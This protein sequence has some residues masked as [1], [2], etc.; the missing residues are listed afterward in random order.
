MANELHHHREEQK[1]QQPKK[2]KKEVIFCHAER[3]NMTDMSC[4]IR[5]TGFSLFSKF[6]LN[7][8]NAK[9]HSENDCQTKSEVE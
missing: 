2:V 7:L 6:E 4:E 1:Q 5:A 3:V 9:C 8:N